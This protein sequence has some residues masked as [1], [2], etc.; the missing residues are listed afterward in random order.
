MYKLTMFRHGPMNALISTATIYLEG[1]TEI[2]FTKIKNYRNLVFRNSPEF[3][4]PCLPEKIHRDCGKYLIITGL[5]ILRHFL[6]LCIVCVLQSTPAPR[7]CR[8]PLPGLAKKRQYWE[9]VSIWS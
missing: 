5:P 4:D 6:Q 7:Y 9:N 3:R 8:L 1:Q 2:V